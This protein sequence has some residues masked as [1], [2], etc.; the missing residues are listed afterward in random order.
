[1]SADKL[2]LLVFFTSWCPN[3]EEKKE[4]ILSFTQTDKYQTLFITPDDW[5]YQERYDSNL[6][7]GLGGDV[8]MIDMNSPNSSSTKDKRN[9]LIHYVVPGRL[10]DNHSNE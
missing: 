4:E 10:P 6:R 1:M 5:I 3:F 2:L 9:L 7:K 8:F